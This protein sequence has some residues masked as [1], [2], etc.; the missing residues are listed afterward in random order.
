VAVPT[1]RP[2]LRRLRILARRARL[3]RWALRGRIAMRRHG[4]RLVVDAPYGAS[5]T[6]PPRL[7]I[8]PQHLSAPV[9]PGHRPVT[10]IVLGAWVDLGDRTTIE[11][12]PDGENRLE[13][14][15]HT[16]LM[17]GVR[18]E[19]FDGSVSI[20][21]GSRIRDHAVLK[22]SGELILG[23]QAAIGQ[24]SILHCA[25]RIVLEDQ[26]GLAERVSIID[27]DHLVDGSDTY[28]QDAPTA[29]TPIHV[30]RN[31]LISANVTLLRGVRLGA[32]SVVAAG[33]VVRGG[34][35]PAGWIMGGIPA[36]PLKALPHA[37]AQEPAG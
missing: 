19:L 9:R 28:H 3:Q 4:A 10:T 24:Q 30:G 27:S 13:V 21:R 8:T 12:R 34:D 15:A 22:S 36:R 31:A 18:I 25:E 35:Y 5:F 23:A 17:T 33:A 6:T 32:N 11:V 20:G 2:L 37:P 14:G 26:A 7:Q 1:I 16:Y 29:S